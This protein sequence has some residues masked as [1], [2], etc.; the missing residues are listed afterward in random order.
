M[1][2]VKQVQPLATKFQLR[3]IRIADLAWILIGG[4]LLLLLIAFPELLPQWAPS[5]SPYLAVLRIPLGLVYVLYAPG[6]LIQAVLFPYQDD[7]DSIERVG[8]SLGLSVAI[9]PLLALLLDWLPWG[10]SLWPIVIGQLLVILSLVVVVFVMR[11]FLPAEQIYAPEVQ[12]KPRRWWRSLGAQ[13]RRLFLFAGVT[14]LFA[15]GAM[16]WIFLVPSDAEF[17]TEFYILGA[18]GLAEDFPREAAVEET[19]TVTM[20]IHNLERAAHTYRVEIWAVDPWEEDRRALVGLNG[21]YPLAVQ[22]GLEVPLTWAMPWSGEDLQTEFLLYID[23]Q[24]EPYRQLR[25]WL[26]VLPKV[27]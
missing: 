22:D 13:D 11:L 3:P 7:L 9:I 10:L 14:L 26:D 12:P 19:L 23:G 15:L 21:P 5:F 27:E 2:I 20:G 18:E 16:A 17:M 4:S 24:P 1:K 6:Y 8:L 25:L